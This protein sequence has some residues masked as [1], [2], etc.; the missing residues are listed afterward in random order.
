MSTQ[1]ATG[2]RLEFS[3]NE[4]VDGIDVAALQASLQDVSSI[5][6]VDGAVLRDRELSERAKIEN[7]PKA[8]TAFV[9]VMI[10]VVA[11]GSGDD[12]G[13]KRAAIER[14][15]QLCEAALDERS[16]PSAAARVVTRGDQVAATVPIAFLGELQADGDIAFID[17]SEALKLD[18]PDASPAARP[19][20]RQIGERG[21]HKNGSDVIIGIVDVGGFDF[22][23]PDFLDRDGNTRFERIWDQGGDFRP[24]PA[25]FGYGSELT[26]ER[27]N[28]AIAAEASGNLPAVLLE[29]Q[30]QRAPSSHATHVASIAAGNKGVC[31]KAEIVGVLVDVPMPDGEFERRRQTFSDSSR[32]VH[33]IEYLLDVAK[34]KGKP[35]SINVSLG[36]NGGAH[37]GL[38][39]TN[40]WFDNALS[41]PGRAITLAAGNAGQEQAEH[42]EDVGWIMGRIHTNGRI[43]A[44]GLESELEW[45]VVG[46]GIADISENELEIWYSPQDRFDVELLPP[47]ETEWL[48]VRAQEFIENKRLSDGTTVSIYNEL[49]HPGNGGNYISIYLSPNLQPG[50]IRGIR[51]G[52]W[53]VRLTGE[54]VRNGRYHCWIERDDPREIGIH[55]G[56][57]FFRFPSFFSPR[58]N[59]DSHSVSSLACGRA[60]IAV[61]NY[62]IATNRMNITSSQGPT[63][64]GRFKPDIAAPG[65]DI[66][67][68]NGF[69]V[70]GKRWT[71]MSGT[72]MASPYVAGVIGL[73]MNAA[74][75]PI[76]SLQ[77][78]GIL[79]RTARPLP[80][81]TFEW[82]DD[83]GFGRIDP[84][85]AILEAAGFSSRTDRTD[86]D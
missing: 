23:H 41:L 40:R 84:E 63:R 69:A 10:D 32:L 18:V 37:D 86:L 13:D 36:T 27:L 42:D 82:V 57:R 6:Q 39:G 19:T 11:S 51:A 53:R 35:I 5:A 68:A 75:G 45:V 46:N 8:E 22:A 33:A 83:A 29:A 70:D 30:S 76:N 78:L 24:A 12:E 65:T 17:K 74:A 26:R 50:E 20:P 52:I 31:P 16:A 54:E 59:V 79:Q 61:S 80:G 28:A 7:E 58:S 15:R 9:N 67:A 44:R 2:P 81:G 73:M 4:L 43:E 64:D 48:K 25:R 34:D 72:S 71:S 85:A 38:A 55:E 3:N 21:L 49:F 1:V 62:D 60:T 66:V 14:I 56:Q 47:G 77:C